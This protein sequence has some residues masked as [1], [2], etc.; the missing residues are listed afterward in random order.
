MASVI[1]DEMPFGNSISENP[2]NECLI[3]EILERENLFLALKRVKANGGSPGQDGMTVGGLPLYLH[4]HWPRIKQELISGRYRPQPV[5]R[6]EIPKPGSGM[7]KLGI[8]TVLD[9]FIQQALL[10]VLQKYW[11]SMFSDFSFGFRP[12]RSAHQAVL[13]AQKYIKAGYRWVVDIDL[14][15]FFDRV[16]HDKLMSEV[17]IRVKD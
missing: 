1:K 6:V 10:Q 12:G 11:D 4:D 5:K 13:Q 16:C 14:E 2:V 3:E 9:R 17:R 8:P 7:R 15:K